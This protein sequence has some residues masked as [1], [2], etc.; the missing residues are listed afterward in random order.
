MLGQMKRLAPVA[1]VIAVACGRPG[2]A[3]A[4]ASASG[5]VHASASIS[6]SPPAPSSAPSLA[7]G[8]GV[9]CGA[10]GCTQYETIEQAFEAIL[11]EKPRVLAVGEAHAQKGKEG[12][13]SSAK[14]FTE[15]V[16]PLL[17]GRASDLVVELLMPNPK[18]EKRT[19]EV[20]EKQAPATTKQAATNQN[21]YVAM[22]EAARRLQIV[23]DLLR[24]SCEDL[25]AIAKAGPDAIAASLETIARLTRVQVEKLLDRN[26]RTPG[27]EDKLVVTYG[28]ALHNDLAPPPE[29][30]AWSF[31]PALSAKVA[32][33]YVE[34]DLFVPE[35]VEDTEIWKKFEWYAHYDKQKLGGKVTVFSPRPRGYVVLFALGAKGRHG[36]SPRPAP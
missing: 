9:P 31:G 32:D 5:S 33:R 29:R 26:A 2:D 4:P 17:G 10:M 7:V 13:P 20:R 16:L 28:G 11:A 21:E 24:P 25:E 12:I 19:E 27:D 35:Y 22:G 6:A 30:A 3:P 8:R 23:P 1:L 36:A 34:V 14:R 15:S 18:C